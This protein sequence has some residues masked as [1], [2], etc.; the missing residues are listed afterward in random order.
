VNIRPALRSDMPQLV[1]L[2]RSYIVDFYQR[3]NP[4]DAAIEA[5]AIH[6]L[7]HPDHGLQF[8]VIDGQQVVGFATLYFTFSTLQVKRAAILNDLFVHA[9]ARGQKIG[10]SLLRHCITY[11]REHDFAYLQWETAKDNHIAQ[12]LYDK[13]GAHRNE[14]LTYEIS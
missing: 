8:V 1:P 14:W 10:E 5:L 12:A 7:D 2:M 13:M 11:I 4:G 9:G 6:L 3:P